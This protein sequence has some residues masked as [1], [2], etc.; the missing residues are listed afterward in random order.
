MKAQLTPIFYDFKRAMLRLSTLT[1]LIVFLLGGIGISY[2]IYS[3]ISQVTQTLGYVLAIVDTNT[4]CYINGVVVDLKGKVV[5]EFEL[6]VRR[7]EPRSRGS[8]L[9]EEV[10]K[11]KLPGNVSTSDP[12]VCR[13]LND[14]KLRIWVT[15]KDLRAVSRYDITKKLV[16]G[17]KLYLT[18]GGLLN[19]GLIEAYS[20]FNEGESA[21]TSP[22]RGSHPP[23]AETGL[24]FVVIIGAIGLDNWIDVYLSYIGSESGEG[25]RVEYLALEIA[26]VEGAQVINPDALNFTLLAAN[27]SS[28]VFTNIRLNVKPPVNMY[29][30]VD[31]DKHGFT[32][33][34]SLLVETVRVG[35]ESAAVSLITG[36][37][38]LSLFIQ[39]FPVALLYLV[40]VLIAKPKSI[41]ALEF[42]VARPITRGDLFVTRLIAGYL[43]VIV[44]TTLFMFAMNASLN[45]LI[46]VSLKPT[47][48]IT[49]Y[50][51]TLA[52]LLT[53][54][55]LYYFIAC[56]LSSGLYLG[57]S[58]SLY[59]VFNI[60]W[61]LVVLA[62]SNIT[63]EGVM[64]TYLLLSYFNPTGSIN[65]ASHY[66]LKH[67]AKSYG[68]SLG[69]I[70]PGVESVVNPYAVVLQPIV[71][72]LIFV[73]LGYKAFKRANLS[74]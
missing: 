52:A 19:V 45:Y 46:G 49:L 24:D 72:S 59:L 1:L 71:M 37:S 16:N 5:E 69:L 66:A 23:M 61:G 68:Q 17:T 22:G 26:A 31:R 8:V 65:F 48:F 35:V 18:Y 55:S 39:F 64:K 36:Q 29:F 56:G 6:S 62:V 57:A 47:A 28:S 10:Y 32:Y 40:Y 25:V 73:I 53:T 54:T 15:H 3:S 4:S 12:T 33:Q 27:V 42:V 34:T 30:V 20:P 58:I 44:S 43:V 41:G 14:A 9:V 67:Y 60:L 63:G 74:Q 21:F 13:L 2:L 7:I 51:G 50:L 38:G 70:E 11:I